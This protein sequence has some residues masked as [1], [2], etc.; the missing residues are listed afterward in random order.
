MLWNEPKRRPDGTTEP[1]IGQP[2]RT[3]EYA[4]W[5][6][7]FPDPG[8]PTTHAV[9][10]RWEDS[11]SPRA[12]RRIVFECVPKTEA[13]KPAETVTP[14]PPPANEERR[15]QLMALDVPSLITAYGVAGLGNLSEKSAKSSPAKAV[16]AIL[17]AEAAN[18]AGKGE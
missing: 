9:V 11:D 18:A 14:T 12:P 17:E 15:K 10:Y 13:G 3:E 1:R 7:Q 6:E 8:A 2:Q 5:C 16:A 4:Q